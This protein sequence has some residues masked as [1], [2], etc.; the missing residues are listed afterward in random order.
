M[1]DLTK[2]AIGFTGLEFTTGMDTATSGKLP[3]VIKDHPANADKHALLLGQLCKSVLVLSLE[4]GKFSVT[5]R[6]KGTDN[7][8]PKP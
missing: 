1:S 6:E 3:F 7:D 2:A 8:S 5:V 4:N